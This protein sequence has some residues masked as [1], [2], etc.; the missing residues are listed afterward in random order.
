[1]Q[2]LAA[3]V[4]E[5]AYSCKQLENKWIPKAARQNVK[6]GRGLKAITDQTVK[7]E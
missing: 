5:L 1:V 6:K 3:C 2:K 7:L 4:Q